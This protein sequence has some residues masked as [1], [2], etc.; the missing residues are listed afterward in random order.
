MEGHFNLGVKPCG[1]SFDAKIVSNL[2]AD[3]NE[4]TVE[5]ISYLLGI[6]T[7]K[8]DIVGIALWHMGMQTEF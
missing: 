5:A 3:R 8:I 7:S 6:W 2:E 4:T 1:L